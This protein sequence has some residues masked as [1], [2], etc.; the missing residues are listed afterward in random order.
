MNATQQLLDK[1]IEA[2]SAKTG[3]VPNNS[4]IAKVAGVGATSIAN[5]RSG[6]SQAAPHAVR[7]LALA[8]GEE[9]AG[10]MALVESERV[11]SADDR[12]AWAAIAKTFGMAAGVLLAVFCY[13]PGAGA[14]P[15]SRA[16]SDSNQRLVANPVIDRVMHYAKW[17][18][19]QVRRWFQPPLKI[20]HTWPIGSP[21]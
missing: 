6:Y 12:R 4:A 21:V 13:A 8:I 16:E 20:L 9:P 17:A 10:W 7:A 2:C 19:Q 15:A 11:R 14:T 18:A 3:A 5:Y 1:Y